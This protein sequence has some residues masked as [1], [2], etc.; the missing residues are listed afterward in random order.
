NPNPTNFN[1]GGFGLSDEA[2]KVKFVFA[3]GATISANGYLIV[4]CDGDRATSTN[5]TFNSGFSLSGTSG[6]AYL[7]NAGG[8]LVN[9]IEYGFQVTDLPI[10]LSSGQWRLLG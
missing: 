5:G 6:G 9:F 1:L 7:F 8:Q 10:G 3:S 2:G 4:W